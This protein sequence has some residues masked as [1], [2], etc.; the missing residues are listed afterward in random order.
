MMPQTAPKLTASQRATLAGLGDVLIPA[1]DTMPSASEAGVAGPLVDAVLRVR[2]DLAEGLAAVLDRTE[3]TDPTDAV[4]ALRSD[5]P[6]G[7]GILTFVVAGG[8]LMDRRVGELLGYPGQEAKEVD[9]HDIVG[10]V[11]SGILDPVIE[12]GPIYRPS[13]DRKA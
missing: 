8:Y 3:G 2:D 1:D 4:E 7:F 13:P 11:S 6:D 12:R 10:F 5:D 9:P